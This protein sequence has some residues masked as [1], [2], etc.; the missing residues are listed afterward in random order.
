MEPALKKDLERLLDEAAKGSL[1]KSMQDAYT[2]LKER[3]LMYRARVCSRFVGVHETNR[4][5]MGL[6]PEHVHQLA[7]SFYDMGFVGSETRVICIELPA[8]D[9]DADKTRSFN[10]ELVAKS[11][12]K[13][14]AGS[15]FVTSLCKHVFCG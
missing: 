9:P 6:S 12:R 1:T 2:L 13:F 7:E 3:G 14:L 15:C 10:A 5:G 4:A 11:N 8:G